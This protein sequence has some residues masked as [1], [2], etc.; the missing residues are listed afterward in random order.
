MISYD[1][2]RTTALIDVAETFG[3][4]EANG[5]FM[6]GFLESDHPAIPNIDV[7]Y[8]FRK[9]Q[10]RDVY[11]F[12]ED[13]DGD[14]FYIH[15][16]TGCGKTSLIR[17]IAA[18]L[19]WPVQDVT[20]HGRM[21]LADLVGQH[22]LVNGSMQF[23]YGPLANAVKHGHILIL[24]EIDLV[25]PSELAGLNGI[26]EGSPLIIASNGG[27]VITPHEKFRVVATANSNGAG[28]SSGLYQGVIRQ[29]G[30]FMDRFSLLEATYPDEEIESVILA[31]SAGAL[32]EELRQKMISVANEVRRIFI[33]E[34]DSDIS[35][36]VTFSTRTLVRWAR[37]TLR[38][39]SP[40][41]P[42]AIEYALFRS[43]TARAEEEERIAIHQ[44]A[45]DIFGDHW[46]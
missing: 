21:E 16:P 35:L 8:V 39:R 46:A 34:A 28:D 9:E 33:G 24:N 43:L 36:S 1:E 5:L 7:D 15:G 26:L 23:M 41:N 30:A 32:P 12:L 42:N 3:L 11:G 2:N 22:T 4:P 29:N 10:F 14:G 18:R 37:K 25:D 6:E 40:A 27:E 13:P 45:K 38:V 31:K 19:H 44:I 17:Q 20:C